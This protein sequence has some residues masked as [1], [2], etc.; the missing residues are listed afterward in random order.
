MCSWEE[1]GWGAPAPEGQL[2]EGPGQGGWNGGVAAADPQ[3]GLEA[4]APGR[5]RV[6]RRGL[7]DAQTL[8]REGTVLF[9]MGGDRVGQPGSVGKRPSWL[10]WRAG[11]GWSLR[12]PGLCAVCA[13][14]NECRAGAEPPCHASARCRNTKGSFRCECTDP[15]LLGDDGWT[16]V[17]ETTPHVPWPEGC[18]TLRGDQGSPFELCGGW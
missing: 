16:C 8:N 7:R 5:V 12:R 18:H 15:Y 2:E 10:W 13:D 6:G 3:E 4:S 9:L 14:V 11:H 1:S 17:G